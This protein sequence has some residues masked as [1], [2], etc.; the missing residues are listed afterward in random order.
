M[1]VSV[2][3]G[4]NEY[5][6]LYMSNG[7]VYNN[8]HCAHCNALTLIGFLAIPK[9]MLTTFKYLIYLIHLPLHFLANKQHADSIEFR[10]FQQNLFHGSLNKILQPLHPGMEKPQVLQYSDGYYW[11][12]IYGL[13]PYIADYPEQVLLACIMQGWC[14]R[15]Y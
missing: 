15:Y 8:V 7:L 11:H 6:L 9:S 2:V 14:P 4:Q 5:Y 3:T 13:G 12:T 1:T 10:R